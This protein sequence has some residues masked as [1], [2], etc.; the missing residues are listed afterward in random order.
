M[1]YLTKQIDS[2]KALSRPDFTNI[3]LGLYITAC[4]FDSRDTASRRKA[5]APLPADTIG[6]PQETAARSDDDTA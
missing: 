6:V 1:L 5:L 2:S 3:E 4:G